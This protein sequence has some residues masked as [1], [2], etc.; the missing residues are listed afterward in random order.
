MMIYDTGLPACQPYDAINMT[1][2]TVLCAIK[3]K[4]YPK[5]VN[6]PRNSQSSFKIKSRK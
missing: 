5:K 6:I 4:M 3:W 1:L 2:L